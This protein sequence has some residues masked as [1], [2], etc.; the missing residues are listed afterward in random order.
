MNEINETENL[1]NKFKKLAKTLKDEPEFSK[2]AFKRFLQYVKYYLSNKDK[3][4]KELVRLHIIFPILIEEAVDE[5]KIIY[6][7]DGDGYF[8]GFELV[9]DEPK[10]VFWTHGF[11]PGEDFVIDENLTK[12]QLLTCLQAFVF[13]PLI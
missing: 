2:K 11:S 13:K 7:T 4:K 10:M 9:D 1:T 5:N 8:A 6:A 3:I 12:E